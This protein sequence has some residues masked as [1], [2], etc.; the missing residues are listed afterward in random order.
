MPR[1]RTVSQPHLERRPEG[2]YWRRRWPRAALRQGW[3]TPSRNPSLCVSLRTQVL[4]EAKILA[5]RLTA[6][7]DQVFAAVAEKTMPIAPDLAETLLVSLVRMRIETAELAREVAPYRS[8]AVAAF[9]LA[10]Q[11]AEQEVLRRALTLRDRSVAREPL[12]E[13]AA[14][15]GVTF[16]EAEPDYQRLAMRALR[17][18]LDVGEENLRRD[19]G[20]YDGP[21][22]AFLSAMQAQP[23]PSGV[24]MPSSGIA[25][26]ATQA[27]TAVLFPAP[28]PVAP[29]MQRAAAL[30][31]DARPSA[32]AAP[33][34]TD[35]RPVDAR[36]HPASDREFGSGA[37]PANSPAV[38]HA[39]S[40]V[41]AGVPTSAAPSHDRPARQA[42]LSPELPRA[43]RDNAFG[44]GLD[45]AWAKITKAFP[46][47]RQIDE[48]AEFTVSEAFAFYAISRC[49]G[50]KGKRASETS[51]VKKG[52]SWSKNSLDNLLATGK[53][54]VSILGDRRMSRVRQEDFVEA[55]N[56]IQRLS[57]LHGRSSK[58][59]RDV[60]ALVEETDRLERDA[61]ARVERE[62]LLKRASAGN[63]EAA[64]H[65]ESIPRLRAATV[66]R[67]MEETQQVNRFMVVLRVMQANLM[68]DVIWTTDERDE[69]DALQE[70]NSR[71]EWGEKLADLFR[72]PIFQDELEDVGDPMFWAPLIAVHA[73]LRMEEALQL[74]CDDIATEAGVVFFDIKVGPNQSLK[75]KSAV[76]RVPLLG[77][78]ELVALRRRQ[79]ED[80]LFPHLK[81]GENRNSLSSLF[82]KDFTRYRQA[83]EVYDNQ[84]DFHSF[85]TGF[86]IGLMKKR[87]AG[88]L[89]K[90]LMG[91][92]IND[93]NLI[94]YG[95]D[96][97][98]LEHLRDVV[99]LIEIDV[100]MIRKPF[101][102][103]VQ[104]SVH[105]IARHRS[106]AR[107]G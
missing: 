62:M 67:Q 92:V 43:L 30:A 72:T 103:S 69:I 47:I 75:T 38:P 59:T 52:A 61:K 23:V 51:N 101:E 77:F 20:I 37:R 34:P 65:Q 71:K 5:Q 82:T 73:G 7:S 60:R 106:A 24:S 40:Y 78:M 44:N 100:S 93:V 104:A 21:G 27:G 28:L 96:G 58:E 86:N 90:V 55:F 105:H 83:H 98:P 87:V 99:N 16:D 17:A 56:L 42:L 48:P 36:P 31:T 10:Q 50:R 84:R 33:L 18:L 25:V 81:R 79:G 97:H 22:A 95:G 1:R 94:N 107:V 4:S 32:A 70:D 29:E 39:P 46:G 12:R 66:Y 9:E 14:Q 64:V 68:Q 8:E 74:R 41:P 54:M 76:R 80:R 35:T 15:L 85:R 49:T 57:A 63:I 11:R 45:Y 6:L 91:H 3:C 102:G 19:Q 26:A 88:E 2:F 13:V 89:R 53:L